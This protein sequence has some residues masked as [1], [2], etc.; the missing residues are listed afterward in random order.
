MLTL[1]TPRAATVLSRK[2]CVDF[3]H[4]LTKKVMS[5]LRDGL[6]VTAP[7]LTNIVPLIAVWNPLPGV[8]VPPLSIARDPETSAFSNNNVLFGELSQTE[9]YPVQNWSLEMP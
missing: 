6:G 4:P 2:C 5:H 1:Y 7:L 3:S 9:I 8:E